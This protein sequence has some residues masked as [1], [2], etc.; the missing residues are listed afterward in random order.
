[1]DINDHITLWS[2]AHSRIA[3]IRR[4]VLRAGESLCAYTIPASIFMMSVRGT[5]ELS[6][7]G[8]A[9]TVLR[10]KVF[11]AGKGARLDIQAGAEGFEYYVI[12]YK[13]SLAMPVRHEWIRLAEKLRPF[14][15]QYGFV[16]QNPYFGESLKGVADIGEGN[17]NVEMILDMQPDLIIMDDTY[18]E[19]NEQLHKI[20]PTVIVPYASLKTVHEEIAYFGELL[21]KEK[22]AEQWL[23]DY[24][25]RTAEAKAKVLKAVPADSTFSVLELMDKNVSAVG[26]N[27]G[28][29]GQPIYGA[30]GFKPPAV[31]GPELTDPGWA[32]LSSETLPK[33]AGDYIILTSDSHTL[34]DLKADPIWNSLDA[35]KNDRVFLWESKRSWYWDPIAILSQTEELA[36]WLV[37]IK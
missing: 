20:A 32:S 10:V 11:H 3:D 19:M 21:G 36:D 15:V 1:M 26:A 13:A 12:Y 16:I 5:A 34:E 29:G 14:H 28:K 25:R 2:H 8:S 31:V 24:D 17:G 27:Y 37:S 9:H 6:L 18:P 33:Y 30:F 7:D 23:A 4:V 35:V 22:E